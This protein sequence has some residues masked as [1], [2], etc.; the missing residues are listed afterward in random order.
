MYKTRYGMNYLVL[1]VSLWLML[2]SLTGWLTFPAVAVGG[3]EPATYRDRW[4][5]GEDRGRWGQREGWEYRHGRPYRQPGYALPDRY[6]IHKG[7]K[8]E[9]RCQRIWGTNDYQCREYRC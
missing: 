3:G 2:V 8:C 6:T 4:Y 1:L 9:L 7:K 5:G